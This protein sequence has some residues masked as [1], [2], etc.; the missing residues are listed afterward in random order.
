RLASVAAVQEAVAAHAAADRAA[1][2]VLGR[3]WLYVAFPGG[4][5]DRGQLDAV[6]PDRP[7]FM[8]CFDGHT[9]WANT[10][11]LRLAGIDRGTADPPDGVVVRDPATGE[12]TGALKEGAQELVTRHIPRPTTASTLGAMRRTIT[13]LHAAGITAIQEAWAEPEDVLLWRTLRDEGALRVR[14]RLALPTRP[15]G[16]LDEWKATLE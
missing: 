8:G 2:W 6:V 1:P 10:A 7:A 12:A 15:G 5:P 11:A 9:G 14:A 16:T 4:I 3:G 13:A